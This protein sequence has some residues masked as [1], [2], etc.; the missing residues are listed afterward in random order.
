M[1]TASPETVA[2]PVRR[3][4]FVSSISSGGLAPHEVPSLSYR[5]SCSRI[6][7]CFA[8]NEPQTQE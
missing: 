6:A 1:K 2:T 7:R 8:A 4:C 5:R 3:R